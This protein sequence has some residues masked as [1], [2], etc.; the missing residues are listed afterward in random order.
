M[1]FAPGYENL[2]SALVVRRNPKLIAESQIT[3][4]NLLVRNRPDIHT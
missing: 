2:L 4:D 1:S 3:G